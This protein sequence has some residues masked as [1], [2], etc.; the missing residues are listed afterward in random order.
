MPFI[1]INLF[2]G[3][4]EERKDRIAQK[5]TDA[6]TEEFGIPRDLVWVA[7]EESP[8]TNWTIGGEKCSGIPE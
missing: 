4:P 6:V 7:Y 8:A 1:K 3:H 5:I 2:E